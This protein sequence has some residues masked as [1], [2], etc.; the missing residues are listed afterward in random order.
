MPD[1]AMSHL[2][3]S[4]DRTASLRRHS[5]IVRITHWITAGSVLALIVSGIAILL[6]HPRMYWGETGGVGAPSLFDLP[7]PL[8]LGHSGW[9]RYLHVLSAWVLVFA[10]LTYVLAGFLTRHFRDDL[11][12]ATSDLTWNRISRVVSDHLHWIR[13]SEREAATYNVV[14][15]LTYL[16]VVFALFPSIVW[17]GLAMSPALTSVFPMLVTVLGGHQSA[18]TLHFF[19]ANLLICFLFVHIA[20]LFLV[21]F[22]PHVRAMI[23]GCGESGKDSS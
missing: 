12:P 4:I 15:R 19:A 9:G 16:V 13:P 3:P 1:Q 2:E 6:A 10:G 21:G 20:M 18:R 17:T 14:Q 23:T 7:I 11:L 5:A 22:K 8:T